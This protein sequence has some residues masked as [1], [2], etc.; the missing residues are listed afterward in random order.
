MLVYGE[1]EVGQVLTHL[2]PRQAWIRTVLYMPLFPMLW[3][4]EITLPMLSISSCCWYAREN[5]VRQS[6]AFSCLWSTYAIWPP[7]S[8]VPRI[9]SSISGRSLILVSYWKKPGQLAHTNLISVWGAH[10]AILFQ[11]V[12]YPVCNH[13][14]VFWG[15][16]WFSDLIFYV[17]N[18]LASYPIV[19]IAYL[20]ELVL[21]PMSLCICVH[22]LF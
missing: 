20:S 2:L 16:I 22:L 14:G 12:V 18:K 11:Q 7:E 13:H 9:E 3:G 19:F 6:R 5:W 8:G 15:I 4:Y 10:N 21:H 17:E 1:D